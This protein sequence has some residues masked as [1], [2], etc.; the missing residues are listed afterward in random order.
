MIG[1]LIGLFSQDLA[2]D[3]GSA[4]TRIHMRGAGVVVDV[5]T[6]VATRTHRSGRREL[7]ALGDDAA[8]LIGRTPHGVQAVRPVRA[9]R[10][11]EPDLAVALVQHYVQ[12]L[13]G[14]SNWIRP[15]M[16]VGM[17]HGAPDAVVRS[18]GDL[19][20]A[21]GAREVT[22]L[23]QPIAAA[24]GSG[25]SMDA[26]AAHLLIDIG[27][28]TTGIAV[29]CLNEVI[30]S[31]VLDIGGDVFDG[32]IVRLL[33][34]EHAVLVGQPTAERVKLE[35]GAVGTPRARKAHAAGRCLRRGIPRSVE[36]DGE[37]IAAV[38]REPAAAIGA[39]IRRV[40]ELTP[41]E[42]AA[43]VVDHGALLCG[44]G[45]LLPGLD[46]ALRADTGLAMLPGDAPDRAVARG[47]GLVMDGAANLRRV[48]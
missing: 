14:R 31:T 4:R 12:S 10:L 36:L 8:A 11:A 45:S 2:L 30:A 46:A 41:R 3:L 17:P 7:I 42:I 26:S 43:D 19:C 39:G 22:H 24:L 47:L 27:A 44:G 1:S 16:L 33:K 13:H 28:G 20:T 37:A 6:V 40:L 5:P 21:V 9:G 32:A 34:R 48:A 38:L 29:V 35:L 23:P 18:L 25:L 15:R